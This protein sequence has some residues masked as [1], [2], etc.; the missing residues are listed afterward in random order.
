MKKSRLSALFPR[1]VVESAEAVTSR[2]GTRYGDI[3]SDKL[4]HMLKSLTKSLT[5]PMEDADREE[6]E[7]KVD[8]IQVILASR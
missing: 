1:P 6:K 8:A 5:A 4:A 2:D 3:E 7:Y